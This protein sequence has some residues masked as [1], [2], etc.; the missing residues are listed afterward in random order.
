M[1]NNVFKDTRWYSSQ[2]SVRMN[3]VKYCVS[4][5]VYSQRLAVQQERLTIKGVKYGVGA[6]TRFHGYGMAVLTV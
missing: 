4:V 1:L 6:S 3:G 5:L 2:A